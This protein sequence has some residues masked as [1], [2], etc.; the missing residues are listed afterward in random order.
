MV[1]IF[2]IVRVEIIECIR[3]EGSVD[4]QKVKHIPD[5]SHYFQTQLDCL[6]KDFLDR[7]YN[8]KVSYVFYYCL[9]KDFLDRLYALYLLSLLVNRNHHCL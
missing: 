8:M 3:G 7:L 1:L 6:L 2:I 9:L 4:R 5:I